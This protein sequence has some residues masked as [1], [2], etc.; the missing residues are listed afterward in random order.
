M[1]PA[2]YSDEYEVGFTR[3]GRYE[4]H[5]QDGR[6]AF[7]SRM[8]F[9]SNA[10]SE[11]IV[12]HPYHVC[13]TCTILQWPRL[14]LEEAERIFWRKRLL[15]QKE[16]HFP[17]PVSALPC[18]PEMDLLHQRLF[19]ML[20]QSAS[21]EILRVENI[22]LKILESLFRGMYHRDPHD[23][24]FAAGEKLKAQHL[25]TVER[26][27][28]YMLEHLEED[29]SLRD[30]AR[31][32][33]VSEFHFS[34]IFK[35]L[36]SKSP[37]QYLLQARLDNAALL[38]RETKLPVT[39]VALDSGFKNFPHFIVSFRVRYGASPLQYRKSA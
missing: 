17:F 32:A 16:S 31:N 35:Q 20:T 24:V 11:R 29:I 15:P 33:Y 7:D 9:L 38:L 14:L 21:A 30:I 23:P 10:E 3:S 5:G 34:R 18:T 39:E 13:D 26:A 22:A 1:S 36:T 6:Y 25:Q 12:I 2:E 4:I 19:S 8:V 37:Y 27:K 28:N